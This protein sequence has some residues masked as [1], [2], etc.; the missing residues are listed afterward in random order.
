MQAMRGSSRRTTARTRRWHGAWRRQRLHVLHLR[1]RL[2]RPLGMVLHL[3]PAMVVAA[4]P[5]MLTLIILQSFPIPEAF[6]R[7]PSQRW[8]CTLRAATLLTS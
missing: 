1:L 4:W 3:V 8:R 2:L 6:R 7:L 5:M